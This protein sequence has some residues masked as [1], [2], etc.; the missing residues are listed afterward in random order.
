MKSLLWQVEMHRTETSNAAHLW[1]DDTLHQGAGDRGVDGIT[2]MLHDD[3][4]GLDCL[5]LGCRNDAA[6][7]GC[8]VRLTFK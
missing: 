5:G 6:R 3:S 7:H 2:T 4:A 1:V 8:L